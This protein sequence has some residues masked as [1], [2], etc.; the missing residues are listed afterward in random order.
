MS[1]DRKLFS[2]M[3]ENFKH[4]VLL[5]N[6]KQMEVMGKGSVRLVL[7][8]AGYTIS[9]VYY[10]PELKNNLLSISQLQEKELTIIIR[11]GICK[12]YHDRRG[13]MAERKMSMNIMFMLV[14]QGTNKATLSQE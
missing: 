8:D 10:V 9:D 11:K 5:G 4:S 2:T 1:G 3:D 7:D 12:I 6:E 13:L 14:D